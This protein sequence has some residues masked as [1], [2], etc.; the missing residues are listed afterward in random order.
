MKF[1]QLPMAL[2]VLVVGASFPLQAASA[3][4]SHTHRVHRSHTTSSA[5]PPRRHSASKAS[6]G[7]AA[8]KTGKSRRPNAYQRLAKMQM[9]PSRVE[10][11]QKALGDAG[12]Y[13]GSPTGRWDADTRDAM[14]RYQSQH[15]FGVTGL[16]DA[17]SLMKLGLGPHPLPAALDKARAANTQPNP[18]GQAPSIS[19]DSPATNDQSPASAPAP[20][21]PPDN[22]AVTDAQKPPPR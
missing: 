4:T 17:K 7:K 3:T 2:L 6:K 1:R 14:A 9:D 22:G 16:P 12:A 11:I 5:T 20:A 10:S 19:V 13:H 21:T 18:A 8:K 15:G